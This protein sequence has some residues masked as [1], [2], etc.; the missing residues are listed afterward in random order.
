MESLLYTSVFIAS[1]FALAV[2]SVII[3]AVDKYL[4][5]KENQKKNDDI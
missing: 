5:E 4:E 1:V 2:V 3:I